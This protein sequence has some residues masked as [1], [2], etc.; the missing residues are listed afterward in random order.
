MHCGAERR[1]SI[2]ELANGCTPCLICA[3]PLNP[4]ALHYV[5]L[6]HFPT[7]RAYKI[8][9]T[10]SEA[11]LDR[12][13]VHEANGGIAIQVRETP[14]R[15]A[16][17]TVEDYV[18]GLVASF[19][20]GCTSRDFPQGG[21]TETWG[22]DAGPI[23]L[24]DIIDRLHRQR[25]PGFDRLDKLEQYFAQDPVT[26]SELREFVR[27][28]VEDFDGVKVHCLS[29]TKPLEQVLGKIRAQRRQETLSK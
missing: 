2:T 25:A 12:I 18:L 24:D 15:Q 20:S 29:T 21:Y 22:E 16:A 9:I 1:I 10:N 3:G 11:R 19:P 27:V 6:M 8:G 4:D 17:T 5:Y 7:L 23:N 26:L 28:E 14:N 13:A